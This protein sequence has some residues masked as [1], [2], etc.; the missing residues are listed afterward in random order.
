MLKYWSK[1]P[2]S[3]QVIIS[4]TIFCIFNTPNQ[5]FVYFLVLALM[6]SE[7]RR[8]RFVTNQSE[9]FSK[10][11]KPLF[12][13]NVK[14][15]KKSTLVLIQKYGACRSDSQFDLFITKNGFTSTIDYF[16]NTFVFESEHKE[17]ISFFFLVTALLEWKEFEYCEKTYKSIEKILK[18]KIDDF[19]RTY[20]N[21]SISPNI[22]LFFKHLSRI[23]NFSYL[24]CTGG[25]FKKF[26]INDKF[27]TYSFDLFR[28][29]YE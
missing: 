18:D 6:I 2:G 10:N 16:L 25:I 3:F 22:S 21:N 14:T 4:E 8:I 26:L 1:F 23:F 13:E 17:Y 9:N 5:R 24:L 11:F 20:A 27:L 19:T 28:F 7:P 12:F 29:L 15:K